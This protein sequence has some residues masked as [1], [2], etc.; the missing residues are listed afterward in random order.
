MTDPRE[1][2]AP[3]RRVLLI[4]MLFSAPAAFVTVGEVGCVDVGVYEIRRCCYRAGTAA[5]VRD[6]LASVRGNVMLGQ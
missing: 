1:L 2:N 5:R 4:R 6:Q 3:G